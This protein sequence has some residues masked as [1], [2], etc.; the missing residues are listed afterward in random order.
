MAV[1][2]GAV[3]VVK[4][5]AFVRQ[6]FELGR[7]CALRFPI[8]PGKRASPCLAREHGQTRLHK[9]AVKTGVVRHNQIGTCHHLVHARIV[10]AVALHHGTVNAG[11]LHDGG[12]DRFTRVFKVFVDLDY[13]HGQT[14]RGVHLHR[15]HGQLN[16]LLVACVQPGGF[17]V[18][19]QHA[20]SH[21]TGRGR[22]VI[23][24]RHQAAQHFVVGVGLQ[25]LRHAGGLVRIWRVG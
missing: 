6:K 18:Q 21:R 13:A 24:A 20:A 16:D 12:W 1:D 17:G 25:G 5:T 2:L 22:A 4:P 14:G 15:Q 19:N 23:R 8:D 9:R 10:Q 3:R 7:A 11:D